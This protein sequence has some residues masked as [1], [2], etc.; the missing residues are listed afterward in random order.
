MGGSGEA[1]R[2]GHPGLSLSQLLVLWG[3]LEGNEVSL[4]L[5]LLPD[6]PL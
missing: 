4:N 3:I 5:Q 6:P 1:A 2:P